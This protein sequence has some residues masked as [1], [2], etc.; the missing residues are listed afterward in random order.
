MSPAPDLQPTS[1]RLPRAVK[2]V[3]WAL[4]ALALLRLLSLG[5]Y[6]LRD[7]TEAR[8]GEIARLMVERQDWITPWFDENVPFWGKPPASFW[9]TAVSFKLFGLNEF[10][11]RLPHWLAGMAVIALTW[12]LAA[13]R[14]LAMA[15]YTGAVLMGSALFLVSAGAVMT[16]MAMVVGTTLA[17]R[18]FWLGLHGTPTERARERW[19]MA[20]GMGIGLLAKGPIAVV[21]SGAPMVLWALATRQVAS[22]W[23]DLPWIRGVLLTLLIAGPWYLLAERQTPGFLNY[24]IVGEHWNRFLVPGWAGDLYGTAHDYPRGTIWLF[25]M[26][27]FMPWTVLLPVYVLIRL[28]R[29]EA[30]RPVATDRT[31]RLYLWLWCLLPGLF[32]T[33]AGNILWPYVLPGFPALALLVGGWLDRDPAPRRVATLIC[34]GLAITAALSTAYVVDLNLSGKTQE[35]SQKALVATYEAQRQQDEPLLYL[36]RRQFSADFYSRGRAEV[37]PEVDLLRRRLEQTATAFV[38]VANDDVG[39]LPADW[40][41]GWTRVAVHGRYTLFRSGR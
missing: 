22:T 28:M 13:R 33:F 15:V 34:T 16:D 40:V 7:T 29:R 18:G 10:A 35:K 32:F 39:D 5:F 19:L 24:F 27:D 1:S 38:A 6:P 31:W 36:G 41:Q 30:D 12:G 3:L 20:L 17:F 11:A 4:V 23:R 14:S 9:I 2:I 26:V 37:V 8:Y 21:L 25:S